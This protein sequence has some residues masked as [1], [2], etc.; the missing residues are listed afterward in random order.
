MRSLP[1]VDEQEIDEEPEGLGDREG[2]NIDRCQAVTQQEGQHAVTLFGVR[3]Q[4]DISRAALEPSEFR[5]RAA[6]AVT[7]WS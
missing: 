2:Y 3:S 7:T 5:R 6:V 4:V 1:Q